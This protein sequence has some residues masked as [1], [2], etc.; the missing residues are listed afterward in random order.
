MN[1]SNGIGRIGVRDITGSSSNEDYNGRNGHVNKG[2][3]NY[4]NIHM[5]PAKVSYF[6]SMARF[7]LCEYSML[8][9][10]SIGFSS[11]NAGWINGLQLIGGMLAAPLWSLLADKKAIHKCLSLFI[12]IMA[13]STMTSLP[14]IN[15][16]MGDARRTVCPYKTN[17]GN[18]TTTQRHINHFSE[19]DEK[20]LFYS[21]LTAAIIAYSFDSTILAFMD[22]GVI[23]RMRSSPKESVYGHQRFFGG[24]GYS[25]GSMVYST[26]IHYFPRGNLSCYTAIFVV[27][28]A[29]TGSLGIS[30]LVLFS[31]MKTTTLEPDNVSPNTV[32]VSPNT[33]KNVSKILCSTLFCKRVIFFL[34]SVLILGILQGVWYAFTFVYM[35]EIGAPT[36]LLGLSTQSETVSALIIYVLSNKLITWLGGPMPV[37]AFNCFSWALRFTC[38]ARMKNPFLLLVINLSHGFC[39]P[40]CYVATIEYIKSRTDTR[41]LTTMVG[42]SNTLN[43]SGLVIANLVGGYLYKKYGGSLLFLCASALACVWCVIIISIQKCSGLYQDGR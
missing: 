39:F 22:T 19:Y 32:N 43:T 20:V 37:M 40:L 30:F 5:V 29:F 3:L 4:I 12:C 14:L 10:V 21:L 36:L 18:D 33:G 28:F 16:T 7:A 34:A 24:I 13:I 31:G 26:A 35:K 9:Y 17:N 42:I 27:Y 41:V 15:Q 1:V 2:K 8:F 25:V 23:Q 38:L 11:S 6:L